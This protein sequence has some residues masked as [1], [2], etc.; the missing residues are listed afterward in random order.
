MG[1]ATGAAQRIV[2]TGT[3]YEH[4]IAREAVLER[5][6]API[7]AGI[8]APGVVGV[9]EIA[10]VQPTVVERISPIMTTETV[11][12]GGMTEYIAP[13]TYATETLVAPTTYIE[14]AV[15]TETLVAPTTEVVTEQ[16]AYVA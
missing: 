9:R 6:D 8:Y 13:T 10:A 14:P 3:Q 7:S 1:T 2:Q 15:Y 5:V 16:F 11:M 12:M 4:M